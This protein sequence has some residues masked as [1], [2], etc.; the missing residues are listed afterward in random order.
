MITDTGE[1]DR[2]HWTPE[3][4]R[5]IRQS[6]SDGG[7]FIDTLPVGTVVQAITETSTYTVTIV[8]PT[9]RIVTIED[10]N[11]FFIP[12]EVIL[13]GSTWGGSMIRAGWIGRGMY[14][15]IIRPERRKFISEQVVDFIVQNE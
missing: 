12:Q 11:F 2:S 9:K 7:V 13:N 3:I 15:E 4:I 8:D 5:N 6:N 10:P 14:M 1:E